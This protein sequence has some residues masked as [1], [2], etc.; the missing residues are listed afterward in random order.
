MIL[1]QMTV[2]PALFARQTGWSIKPQGACKGDTCVPLPAGELDV[3][4]LSDRLGMALVED[5]GVIALGPEVVSGRALTT[6]QAPDLVLPDIDGTPF[7]LSSLRGQKVVLVT[8]ASWCGCRLDLGMWQALRAELHPQGLE[9]VTVALDSGGP[10]AVRPWLDIAKPEHPSLIDVAHTVD[11]LLGVVNV[12]NCLWID[13]HGVIVRP[14][15]PGWPGRT[16]QIELMEKDVS[17][18]SVDHAEVAAEVRK[19]NIDPDR[20]PRMLRDWVAKGAGSE[21]VMTPD[22]VIEHSLPRGADESRAAAHFELGQ[23]LHAAGDVA[24]AVEHWR[25][26]HALQPANWTYK[27]QAWNLAESNSVRTVTGYDSGWL[28]DVRALGAESYYPAPTR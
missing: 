5:R 3:R 17:E 18:L 15:E 24:G 7:A 19:M 4:V 9:V 21:F 26:A 13:E 23:H 1:D 2:D 14:A 25:R 12:P 8:W 20:Y 6:A 28:A 27:R 11:A 16:P 22:E 10:D